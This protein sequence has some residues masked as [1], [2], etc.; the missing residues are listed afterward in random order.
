MHLAIEHAS[1]I[2]G[3]TVVGNYPAT[4]TF[5]AYILVA[6]GMWPMLKKAGRP[7]WGG[8][9]PFY[10]IYLQIKLAGR[11]GILLLL[12]FVPVVNVVVAIVVAVGVARAFGKGGVYG[13]FLLFLLQPLGYL[14]LGFGRAQYT[15]IRR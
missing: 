8:F 6:I 15:E 5:I 13:F 2:Y 1:D 3:M 10:N 14:I 7:P 9:V 4:G 11:H 12:Y